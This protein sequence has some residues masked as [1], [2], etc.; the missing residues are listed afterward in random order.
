[1][2]EQDVAARTRLS[3]I[4]DLA[5]YRR[6]LQAARNPDDPQILVC[7]GTGC[8][9]SGAKKLLPAL[10]E[11]LDAAGVEAKVIDRKSVV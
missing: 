11:A 3:S 1:M 10:V 6:E 9:A 4:E 5:D 2:F 8:I 7:F